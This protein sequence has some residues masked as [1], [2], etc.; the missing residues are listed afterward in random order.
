M[1]EALNKKFSTTNSLVRLG[2]RVGIPIPSISTGLYTVDK[3][4]IQSGGIPRGRIIE[5]FGP[6]SSGK[7]TIALHI[8]G[9][10]QKLGGVCAFV[11]VEHSLDPTWASRLGVN[12]DDLVVAQPDTGEQA[13]ETV[14]ALVESKLVTLIVVDSVSALVPRAELEGDM[15]DAHIGLQARLMSQAMRKLVGACD[16][17]GVTVLFIN[18]IREKVGVIFGSPETTSGGKALK[19]YAS[20]RLDVRRKEAVKEGEKVIGQIMKIKAVKNKV[21][22]PYRETLVELNYEN[23]IDMDKDAIAYAIKEGVIV[24]AG[25]WYKYNGENY[26]KDGLMEI[27]PQ[28]REDL[29]K[30]TD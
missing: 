27:L 7:T 6:E 15:G 25:A 9:C 2:D 20:V 5:L 29:C 22:A 21:A 28:V 18:Q 14:D 24:Q 17:N 16:R 12:V 19:F 26:R 3:D 1:E 30:T 11:D 8:I 13:L 23:G 10:E 4:V